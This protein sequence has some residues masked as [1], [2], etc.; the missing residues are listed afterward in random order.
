M[1]FSSKK[2]KNSEKVEFNQAKGEVSEEIFRGDQILRGNIVTRRD[3]RKGG[4]DYTVR[5]TNFLGQPIGHEKH[6]EVKANSWDRETKRQRMQ[7]KKDKNYKRIDVN[8][9]NIPGSNILIDG[10]VLE[11]RYKKAKWLW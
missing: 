7:R 2:R 1:F 5:G 8:I 9:D 3:Q 11:K 6:I 10:K 4:W